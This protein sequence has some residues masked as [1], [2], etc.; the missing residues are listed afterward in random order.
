MPKNT[1]AAPKLYLVDAPPTPGDSP[2]LTRLRVIANGIDEVLRLPDPPPAQHRQPVRTFLREPQEDPVLAAEFYSR[3]LRLSQFDKVVIAVALALSLVVVAYIAHS[4]TK[5]KSTPILVAPV[6]DLTVP[7]EPHPAL[8]LENR[9]IAVKNVVIGEPEVKL[10]EQPGL[11][12][13]RAE[14]RRLKAELRQA[15]QVNDVYKGNVHQLNLQISRQQHEITVQQGIASTAL[16]QAALTPDLRIASVIYE[17][18]AEVESGHRYGARGPETRNGGQALGETQVM[19][20]NVPRWS[21]EEL[22]VKLTPEEYLAHPEAQTLVARGKIAKLWQQYKTVCQVAAVWHSGRP[23]CRWKAVTDAAGMNTAEYTKAVVGIV[24]RVMGN[25]TL[26]P[27]GEGPPE[28][29][30]SAVKKR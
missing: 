18:I 28:R 19:P 10:K 4:R 5:S 11:V 1:A 27:K 8:P 3:G 29:K 15:Q 2:T 13:L 14:L 12:K 21:E 20:T 16:A 26:S 9:M 22:G 25:V 7:P 17:A 23:D 24:S 30:L 6:I